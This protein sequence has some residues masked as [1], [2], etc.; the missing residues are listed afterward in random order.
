MQ[1]A[2]MR[3]QEHPEAAVDIIAG[4]AETTTYVRYYCA[5]CGK[6]LLHEE[7]G[8]VSQEAWDKLPD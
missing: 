3:C 1:V 7:S 8:T 4:D 6:L 5:I 2:A